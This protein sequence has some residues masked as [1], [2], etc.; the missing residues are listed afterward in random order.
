MVLSYIGRAEEGLE[1]LRSAHRADPYIGPAWYWRELGVA[2]FV[3]HRYEAASADFDRAAIPDSRRVLAMMAGCSA[4]LG[5]FER[6][7]ESVARCLAI[8]PGSTVD[9][10]V[11]TMPFK[12]LDDRQHFVECLRL[13]GFPE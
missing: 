8:R 4:K 5:Q 6:A 2:Q 13:A 3:L 10:L 7:H 9:A 11:A 12:N 1:L